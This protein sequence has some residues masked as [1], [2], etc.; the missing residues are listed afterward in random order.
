MRIVIGVLLVLAL[1]AGIGGISSYAYH[2][3]LAEGLAQTAHPGTPGTNAPYPP[4]PYGYPWHGPFGFG[5][6]GFP[7]FGFVGP[8]LWI[9]LLVVLLRGVFWG[10]RGHWARRSYGGGV[11]P[12]FEEWHRRMHESKGQTGTA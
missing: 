6:F 2:V 11:P 12:W 4:Y 1:A 8:L 10:S 5:P 7:F 9:L 3:G